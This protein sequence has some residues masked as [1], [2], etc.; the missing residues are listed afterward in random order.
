MK[1]NILA[2]LILTL[3]ASFNG[4]AQASEPKFYY[5][6]AGGLAKDSVVKK[7]CV[8]YEIVGEKT[9]DCAT[10]AENRFTLKKEIIQP[11]AATISTDNA[12]IK[13]LKIFWEIRIS[14]LISRMK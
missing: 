9:D 3:L 2:A 12:T 14:F 11:T 10:V 6:M 7:V 1:K 13:P 5:S 8:E 4:F